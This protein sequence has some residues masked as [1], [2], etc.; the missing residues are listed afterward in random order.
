[1]SKAESVGTNEMTK[2][3]GISAQRI[4]QLTEE[5]VIPCEVVKGARRFDQYAATQAYIGYLNSR[6]SSKTTQETVDE[7]E[8]AEA[9]L[10]AAKATIAELELA[11]LEGRMHSAED[12][13]FFTSD[14]VIIFRQLLLAMPGQL[15]VDI[16]AA[17]TDVKD[18]PKVSSLIKS[19][20]TQMLDEVAA[21]RYDPE[22]YRQRVRERKG[23]TTEDEQESAEKKT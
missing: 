2:L 17:L 15:A 19:A 18:A 4:R 6:I 16:A 7:K 23:W 5:N 21:Y 20:V 1:M 14:I 11:E 3:L 9:R 8:A 13:E 12:V 10:K 22:Q